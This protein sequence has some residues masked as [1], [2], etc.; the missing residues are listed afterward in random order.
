MAPHRRKAANKMTNPIDP[1]TA[2]YCYLLTNLWDTELSKAVS[3]AFFVSH[4]LWRPLIGWP[5]LVQNWFVV[6]GLQ[7][8][9]TPFPTTLSFSHCPNWSCPEDQYLSSPAPQINPVTPKIYDCNICEPTRQSC[10]YM[11]LVW[12]HSNISNQPWLQQE[13]TGWIS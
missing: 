9:L 4:W 2:F 3:L 6:F 5:Y 11:W 1:D 12:T 13:T 10:T 8:F 7:I